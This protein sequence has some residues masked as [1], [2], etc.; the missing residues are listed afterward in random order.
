MKI[1]NFILTDE[2]PVIIFMRD[3]WVVKIGTELVMK[4]LMSLRLSKEDFHN[5][6]FYKTC[7]DLR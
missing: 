2:S 3:D 4:K 7:L 6:T 5:I 1:K